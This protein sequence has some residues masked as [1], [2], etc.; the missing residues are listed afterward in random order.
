MKRKIMGKGHRD[1]HRAR[2]KIDKAAFDK[3]HKRRNPNRRKCILCGTETRLHVLTDGVCPK[4]LND[5][6]VENGKT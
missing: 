1:N 4:F 6:S 5:I 3:K 2:I